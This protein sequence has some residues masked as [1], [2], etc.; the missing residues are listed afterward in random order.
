MASFLLVTLLLIDYLTFNVLKKHKYVL[1]CDAVRLRFF[2]YN[3]WVFIPITDTPAHCFKRQHLIFKTLG[4]YSNPRSLVLEANATTTVPWRHLKMC[5]LRRLIKI[6]FIGYSGY[7]KRRLL[8]L[9]RATQLHQTT[10]HRF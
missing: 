7:D 3:F 6:L 5:F 2:F 9:S 4:R 8:I 1:K 10:L